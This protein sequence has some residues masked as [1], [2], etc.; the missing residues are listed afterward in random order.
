MRPH[1]PQSPDGR[2]IRRRGTAALYRPRSVPGAVGAAEDLLRQRSEPGAVQL[3][4]HHG[5][6]AELGSLPL[7]AL[8]HGGTEW[9]AALALAAMRES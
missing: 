3:P 6:G 1:D 4:G 2:A 8:H 5:G 7:L 9:T